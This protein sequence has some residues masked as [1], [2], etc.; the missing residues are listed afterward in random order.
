[1][2]I[3]RFAGDAPATRDVQTQ[4]LLQAAPNKVYLSTHETCEHAL[5]RTS[6]EIK[7]ATQVPMA[8]AVY[9]F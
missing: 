3:H 1:M 4:F 9:R 8:G 7:V 5:A 6:Q 2:G